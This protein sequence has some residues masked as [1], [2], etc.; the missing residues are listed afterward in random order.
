MSGE[1][2]GGRSPNPEK[3]PAGLARGVRSRAPRDPDSDGAG[4]SG[5]GD[6]DGDLSP[7]SCGPPLC[8]MC[9][10]FISSEE[11]GVSCD[12]IVVMVRT[13]FSRAAREV[14]KF[15]GGG[16]KGGS[17]WFCRWP[18]ALAPPPTPTPP[19]PSP[20]LLVLSSSP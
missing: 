5:W 3:T 7:F 2:P 10:D 12:A 9:G 15:G 11:E 6:G 19:P 18:F 1:E 20:L 14:Q 17:N 13:W 4:L 8:I 16:G